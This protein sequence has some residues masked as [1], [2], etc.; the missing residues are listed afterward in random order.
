MGTKHALFAGL[1]LILV[2]LHGAE[3]TASNLP[4]I[5]PSQPFTFAVLGDNRGDDS[6]DQPHAFIEVIRAVSRASPAFVLDSGDMIYGHTP[7]ESKL[8]D[9]WRRYREAIKRFQPPMFHVPGNHDIWDENSGRIYR[10]LWGKPYYSF[11]HGNTRF[12]GLDT[13]TA[14]GQLGEEQLHWLEQQFAGLTQRNVFVFLHRPLFPIDG[15]I[16]SSL[17]K[18]P[19]ERD[20]IHNLFVRNRKVIRGVF[21]GHEH[22]YN[23]QKRD[24]VPYYISGGG[25]APL[26]MAP[27][28]G[29]FHHFLLV[30]VREDQ[31]DVELHKVCAPMQPLEPPRQVKPGELLES[32]TEGLFWYGWDR[33]TTI[34]ET[35]EKASAGRRGLR[36]NFDLA[37]YAWPVLTLSL[38][39]A[40]DLSGSEALDLDVY[41]PNSTRASL[42]VTPA[43]QGST[44]HEGP[45]APLKKGWNTIHTALDEK[46]LPL[47]ER[48]NVAGVEWSLST[49]G[50]PFEGWVVF[51]NLRVM[52]RGTNR[53]STP[54][55]L[56]SWERPLLWRVFDETVHAEIVRSSNP[57]EQRGLLLYPDFAECNR[58]VLFARLNPPWDLTQANALTLQIA[59]PDRVPNDLTVRLLLWANDVAYNSP[60]RPLRP[61]KSQMRF[62]LDN[63]WLPQQT[64]RAVEQVGFALVSASTNR[65]GPLLFEKLSAEG[66]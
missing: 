29:G 44:K 19:E 49:E 51:D 53:E 16:G 47:S 54:Q 33:T 23:F 48:T 28:L 61:G 59:V 18:Y 39:S 31:V 37:Q 26:Y 1:F 12:I 32:W 21:A 14:N 35:A 30:R 4:N 13:E 45:A 57:G 20:R 22:L 40:W 8:R 64:Q 2:S 11:D 10:E 58:P 50:Q 27:E 55:L 62:D 3:N 9:Q 66:H 7:D 52:H 42:L 15:G 56:E 5:Q 6:G 63:S 25:G 43:L 24:G 46:W 36:L 65:A 17:D 34:E 38:A 41:V 60:S